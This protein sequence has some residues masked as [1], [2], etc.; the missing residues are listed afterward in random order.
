[1]DEYKDIVKEIKRIVEIKD[2]EVVPFLL[3]RS[4]PRS[5][6]ERITED[7]NYLKSLIPHA[8]GSE[9]NLNGKTL[10]PA[11]KAFYTKYGEK[12]N[13]F[14]SK[15]ERE[16]FIVQKGPTLTEFEKTEIRKIKG[17]NKVA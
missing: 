4:V 13:N 2:Y 7:L 9:V 10:T 14:C 12:T 1:V 16:L 8:E 6:A 15:L 17:E 3:G 11:Q 5:V